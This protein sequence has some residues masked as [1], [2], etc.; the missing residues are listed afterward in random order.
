MAPINLDT[1]VWLFIDIGADV[2]HKYLY[3]DHEKQE[4]RVRAPDGDWTVLPAKQVEKMQREN[5][6]AS[7]PRQLVLGN[8]Y[9]AWKYTRVMSCDN[10]HLYAGSVNQPEN[11]LVKPFEIR[12]L[13][14]TVTYKTLWESREIEFSMALMSG[15]LI[16]KVKRRF[17]EKVM[18]NDLIAEVVWTMQDE[19]AASYRVKLVNKDAQPLIPC[20]PLFT[21]DQKKYKVIPLRK[22][23]KKTPVAHV[24]LARKLP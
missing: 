24:A 6:D 7:P 17:D 8:G 22:I 9:P 15:R 12:S 16:C 10:C 23:M 20:L 18:P 11:L 19:L 1:H 4:L 5:E 2:T 3:V 14:V 21:P 13:V